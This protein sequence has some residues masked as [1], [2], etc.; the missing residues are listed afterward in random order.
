MACRE[1]WRACGWSK[2]IGM[3]VRKGTVV[4]FVPTLLGCFWR[5]PSLY[6]FSFLKCF[7]VTCFSCFFGGAGGVGGYTATDP[8][9]RYA[10]IATQGV[11]SDD[12]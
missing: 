11:S 8:W 7:F 6:V 5:I 10:C 9:P 2:D 12:S 4:S 1:L 3:G